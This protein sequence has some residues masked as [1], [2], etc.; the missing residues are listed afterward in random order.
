VDILARH[1]VLISKSFGICFSYRILELGGEEK[2]PKSTDDDPSLN[3]PRGMITLCITLYVVN[4]MHVSGSCEEA[5]PRKS[6][7]PISTDGPSGPHQENPIEP[8]DILSPTEVPTNADHPRGQK[9]SAICEKENVPAKKLRSI[10]SNNYGALASISSADPIP[11]TSHANIPIVTEASSVC[12][13]RS[14]QSREASAPSTS[15]VYNPRTAAQPLVPKNVQKRAPISSSSCALISNQAT[16][17][18]RTAA[19][20]LVPKYVQ[21]R[22]PISSSAVVRSGMPVPVRGQSSLSTEDFIL[23]ILSWNPAWLMEY[24]EY[25][26][27]APKF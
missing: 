11:S 21:N 26:G 25:M 24:G 3:C 8:E 15:E 27:R 2:L 10:L 4:F 20:P 23:K 13:D 5:I 14:L 17:E 9:R 22:A 16:N 19:P 7:E 18:S 12:G 1:Q 6:A